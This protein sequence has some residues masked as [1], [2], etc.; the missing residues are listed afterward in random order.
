MEDLENMTTEELYKLK[1]QWYKTAI[2]DGSLR[3]CGLVCRELGKD[4]PAKYGPKYSWVNL[5][6]LIEIYVDDY[7]HYMTASWNGKIVLSTHPCSRLFIPGDWFKVVKSF[8]RQ[9]EENKNNRER[10]KFNLERERILKEL[11]L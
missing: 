6:N 4:V 1:K 10:K 5:D 3:I 2:D 8:M 11:K 9:S 7:G